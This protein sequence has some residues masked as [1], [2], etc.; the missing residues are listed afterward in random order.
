M[1]T[2][3][4]VQSNFTPK[5]RYAYAYVTALFMHL[6]SFSSSS[7]IFVCIH[8]WRRRKSICRPNNHREFIKTRPDRP[9]ATVCLHAAPARKDHGT[10]GDQ[11]LSSQVGL[12]VALQMM[13][14]TRPPFWPRNDGSSWV[15]AQNCWTHH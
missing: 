11:Q 1:Q 10:P 5:I 9:T 2:V 7:A 15:T 6:H 14:V 3:S 13:H 12:T 8:T 4:T